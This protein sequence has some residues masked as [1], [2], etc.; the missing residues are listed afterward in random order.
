MGEKLPSIYGLF[1][2]TGALRYIGKANDPAKRLNGHMRD[3]RR[4]RTPLYDWLAK[5]GRPEI[6]VLEADCGDWP[7]AERRLI[8]EARARG[9]NLLNLADG[10][11]QPK[12]DPD[13]NRRNAAALNARMA[14][15][16]RAKR[17]RLLKAEVGR[18]G[19]RGYLS[20][21]ARAKM[22]MAA[23]RAPHLFGE[24]A[25]LPDRKENPDGSPVAGYS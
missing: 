5:H 24:W 10:G 1:D 23:Q 13:T 21:K 17:I 22:R 16:P 6:R 7:E 14:A 19:K 4:R 8:A 11:D 3:V 15:D 20:N 25:H 9:E 12:S 18:A 2:R